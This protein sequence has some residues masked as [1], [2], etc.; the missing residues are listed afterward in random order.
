MD[1]EW[2]ASVVGSLE[3][4][5]SRHEEFFSLA[6]RF[7]NGSARKGDALV[8][9]GIVR[10]LT[11]FLRLHL[12]IEENLMKR[13]GY[14]DADAQRA[15]HAALLERVSDVAERSNHG[16]DI[17]EDLRQILETFVSHHDSADRRLMAFVRNSMAG[18]DGLAE[19][20]A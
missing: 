14:P 9:V 10:A 20:G 11:N 2:R 7:L 5:D 3:L 18:T 6:E 4:V 12:D 1:S 17:S 19:A 8:D 13:S 15:F 16:Q